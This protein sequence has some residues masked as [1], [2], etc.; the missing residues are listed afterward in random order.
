MIRLPLLATLLICTMLGC[1]EEAAW[2]PPLDGGHHISSGDAS[3]FAFGRTAA[4]EASVVLYFPFNINSSSSHQRNARAMTFEYSGTISRKG[5]DGQLTYAISSSDPQSL[6]LNGRK[7][8][9]SEGMVFGVD[10]DMKIQQCPFIGLTPSQEYLN[11]L[12]AYFNAGE[13]S[14]ATLQSAPQG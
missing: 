14:E 3:I 7:Y 10:E 5:A 2:R 8:D 4:P 11:K 9:L 13:T 1:T 12:R 6:T